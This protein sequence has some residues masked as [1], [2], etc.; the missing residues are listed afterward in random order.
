M[1]ENAPNPYNP[2]FVPSY[3]RRKKN[4]D[5]YGAG[6]YHII[7]K[8]REGAPVFSKIV[9]DARIAPGSPGCADA[10]WSL[11]GKIIANSLYRFHYRFR[12]ID[13]YSYCVMPD[14]VHILLRKS[15]KD[16]HHL[17]Y[18]ISHLK[19]LIAKE[20]GKKIREE[21]S[22]DSIFQENYTDKII[23]PW[24]SLDEIRTYIRENPH[25]LAMRQQYP[26]FFRRVRRLRIGER[27]YEAYGNLFLIRNPE[28][29]AVKISR[30]FSDEERKTR[31]EF[32]LEG[33][34][35]GSVLVSPFISPA[36]KAIRQE[37]EA[38]GAPVILIVHEIFGERFKPSA[39]DFE[40][41]SKGRLLIISLG[42]PK[43]TELTRE[44]CL[45]MNAL[46][47][48]IAAIGRSSG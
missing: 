16:E 37:I 7:L 41:C 6:I 32:W 19:G 11:L 21:L 27:D 34:E 22:S 12:I 36:E 46:A 35:D 25:R 48:E 39:H 31:R 24:R 28:K 33:A 9:G 3:T 15:K 2:N 17:G 4:H 18:F 14:H 5:Y 38:L 42:E 30:K 29:E 43:K 23:F 47:E 8:K 1:R 20:Y 10:E 40:L 13:I 44:L 26:E 45:R